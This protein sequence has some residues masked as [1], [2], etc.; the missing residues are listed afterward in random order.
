[1]NSKSNT[2]AS[3]SG[4]CGYIGNIIHPSVLHA[5]SL[6]LWV[7]TDVYWK[8]QNISILFLVDAASKLEIS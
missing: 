2:E 1:M 8:T 7:S 6:L 5:I 3:L 4:H